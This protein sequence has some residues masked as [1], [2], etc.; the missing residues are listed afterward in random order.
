[1]R[2]ELLLGLDHVGDVTVNVAGC[3]MSACCGVV[4]GGDAVFACC[5]VHE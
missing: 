3:V 4:G 2:V 5:D 1:M